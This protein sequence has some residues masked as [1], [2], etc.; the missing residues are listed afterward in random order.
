MKRRNFEKTKPK[1]DYWEECKDYN[2]KSSSDKLNYN[3]P[4]P[5][6]PSSNK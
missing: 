6:K 5:D 2:L 4:S 1:E 3:K